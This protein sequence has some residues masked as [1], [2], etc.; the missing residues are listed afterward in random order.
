M[1]TSDFLAVPFALQR[2]DSQKGRER[3]GGGGGMPK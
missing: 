1:E 3:G 2:Q